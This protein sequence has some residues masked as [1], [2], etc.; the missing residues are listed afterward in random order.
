MR[1][2]KDHKEKTIKAWMNGPE[3]LT[4]EEALDRYEFDYG[5][6]CESDELTKEYL[7]EECTCA[8]LSQKEVEEMFYKTEKP[9]AKHTRK[10]LVENKKKAN[11]AKEDRMKALVE[12]LEVYTWLFPED[13]TVT[14]TTIEFIDSETNLPVSIKLSKN[15]S[16]KVVTK[17][18]KRK[19][20]TAPFTTTELRQ[21]AIQNVMLANPD[22]FE[23]PSFAGTNFGFA[24]HDI[25]YPFGS[26]KLTNHRK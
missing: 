22:L 26:I 15:K 7:L 9:A 1:L 11:A 8:A 25:K 20:E 3:K 13:M 5:G 24:T 10:E 21:M 2:T 17:N 6:W 18:V 19:D 12:G 14:N 23:A 16:Q 4:L